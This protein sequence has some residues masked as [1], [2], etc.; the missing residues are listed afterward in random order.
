MLLKTG[1]M[2]ENCSARVPT[3]GVFPAMGTSPLLWGSCQVGSALRFF[4]VV[5]SLRS[6]LWSFPPNACRG[7][8]CGGWGRRAPMWLGLFSFGA[9]PLRL[10]RR[11]LPR[12]ICYPQAHQQRDRRRHHDLFG[13]G[14]GTSTLNLQIEFLV[15]LSGDVEGA[16]FQRVF[17]DGQESFSSQ[18]KGPPSGERL[19]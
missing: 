9:F 16:P 1:V 5:V 6:W 18:Q 7:E 13:S 19:S 11:V 2:P 17:F 12:A 10:P 4:F 14:R 3:V 8:R 15:A